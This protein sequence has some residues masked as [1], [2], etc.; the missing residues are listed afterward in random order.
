MNE[1]TFENACVGDRVWWFNQREWGPIIRFLPDKNKI[2]A[3]FS[4][5][6]LVEFNLKGERHGKQELFWAEIPIVAP[7]R[8]KRT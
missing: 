2:F 6:D 3:S 5:F 1:T 4:K 7:P 8:P